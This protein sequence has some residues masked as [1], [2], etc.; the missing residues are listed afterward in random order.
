MTQNKTTQEKLMIAIVQSMIATQMSIHF[1]QEL[2]GTPFYKHD[3]KMLGNK[4]KDVLRKHA[5]KEFDKILDLNENT[6]E[7]LFNVLFEFT[8]EVSEIGLHHI[9]N[10]K[11]IVKAYKK[12]QKSI[13]GIINKINKNHE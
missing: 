10:L 7:E 9:V 13:N 3:L 2:V 8:N 11:N 12:D 1:N 5:S 6:T 4:Y